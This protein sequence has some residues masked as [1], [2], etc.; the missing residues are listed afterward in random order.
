MGGVVSAVF[1]RVT[2][3]GGCS[4]LPELRRDA[5]VF[6]VL[7]RV[8]RDGGRSS[9]LGLYL[10][11]VLGLKTALEGFDTG[12]EGFDRPIVACQSVECSCQMCTDL[13]GSQ[14]RLP[15]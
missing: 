4:S 12:S 14:T 6:A 13:P 10:R 9:L 7:G 3:G 8:L 1:Q 2:R 11:L 5:V 15:V